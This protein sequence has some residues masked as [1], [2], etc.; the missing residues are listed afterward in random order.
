MHQLGHTQ[1]SSHTDYT[2]NLL[3]CKEIQSVHPKGNQSWIFIERTDAEA[4]NPRLWSLDVKNWLIG[5]DSD[6]GKDWSQEEKGMTGWNGWMASPTQW[7]WVWVNS[8]S[9]W[10]AGRSGVL[11]STGSQR[12]GHDWA[13]ELTDWLTDVSFSFLFSVI[14]PAHSR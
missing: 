5:K 9:W 3:D 12:V 10:W 4:E 6:A 2:E 13:T 7:T 14:V 8:R 1:W 11:Q